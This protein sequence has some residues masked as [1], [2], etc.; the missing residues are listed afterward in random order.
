MR[1]ANS[2]QTPHMLV[3]THKRQS[4]SCINTRKAVGN[5]MNPFVSVA[6]I[7]LF[8]LMSQAFRSLLNRQMGANCVWQKSIISLA[9][10]TL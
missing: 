7:S 9:L 6:L 5:E 8:D 4:S 2:C 10:I 1:T 3:H